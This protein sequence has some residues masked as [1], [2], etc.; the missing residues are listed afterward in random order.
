[1]FKQ[2]NNLIKLS[3]NMK[4]LYPYLLILFGLFV[5]FFMGF[6]EVSCVCLLIGIVMIIESVWPEKWGEDSQNV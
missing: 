6:A 3:S 4:K 2:E 1:M 5:L